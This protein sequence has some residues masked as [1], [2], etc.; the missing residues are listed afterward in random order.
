M[1]SGA[2][3][4][5]RS[6]TG[7]ADVRFLYCACAISAMLDDWSGVDQEQAVVYIRQCITYEGGIAV[8]PGTLPSALL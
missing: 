7:E 8:M 1:P 4:A 3:R 2:Y 5:T 6:E